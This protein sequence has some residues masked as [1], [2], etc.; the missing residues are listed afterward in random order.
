MLSRIEYSP[1]LFKGFITS[2]LFYE[3][4]YG[5]EN[6]KEFYYLEVAPGQGQYAWKD[7]NL[8]NLKELNEFE[9]SQFAD[10]SRFIRVYTPT[11][12]YVKVLQ[13]QLSFSFNLK[14][15]RIL[16]EKNNAVAKFI[17]RIATQ[18]VYRVDNKTYDNGEF[19]N[20]K[21]FTSLVNDTALLSTNYALRQSLFFNQ[22]AAV[23]GADYTLANNKN[24][25][26]LLNG[27]DSRD[28][29]THEVRLRLNFL[30]AWSING[31]GVTG[32]KS[33]TSRYFSA[34]NYS[35]LFYDV[36]QKLSFQPSTAFRL[37]GIY[38]LTQKQNNIEGGFQKSIIS[39]YAA[40]IKFNQSE[41][42]S[43][44]LRADFLT[45]S[46]NDTENSPVAYE[47][48]NALRPGYNYTWSISYQR[49][50]SNNIQISINYDGR[51]SPKSKAV[52]IG[53]AQI[54]AFF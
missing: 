54:R 18:T 47:M 40:E 53:G 42:G 1:R 38:K 46:Y 32:T 22:S 35:I 45:I 16:H 39:D 36:E 30:K 34:R 20:P 7:Y 52:H 12:L 37:S 43:F 3:T 51:L 24:K 17:S 15:E 29:L 23:F 21:F 50:L 14:P 33:Y 44:N 4:G 8:N 25:Q 28:N 6:K 41:K 19:F 49:N 48:L 11:N 31:T 9:I 26:L 2:T 13:N 5:L 10:Q 27:Y